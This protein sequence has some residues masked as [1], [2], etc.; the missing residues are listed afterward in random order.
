MANLDYTELVVDHF[1]NPRN[2][3]I[4]DDPDGAGKV[5]SPVCGDMIE[6]QI[7]V[8]DER[9]V[10][11]RYRTFG[12]GAAIASSSM[13]SEMVKGMTTEEALQLTNDDVAAALGGLPSQKLHCSNLAA[14]A[15]HAA[16][17]DYRHR[18]NGHGG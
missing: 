10:D 5:G 17:Q 13:A 12:C 6:F 18:H 8:Q 3:G 14:D 9:I 11:V 15:L 7:K 1:Q 4:M 2:V 16:I